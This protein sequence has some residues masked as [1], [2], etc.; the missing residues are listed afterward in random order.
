MN[1]EV[2]IKRHNYYLD[3]AEKIAK[4]GSCLRTNYGALIINKNDIVSTG[5]TKSPFGVNNCIDKKVCKR[6]ELDSPSGEY[7]ECF[8]V[9]AEM[10][11][12]IKANRNKLIG[13]TLYLVGV[14][15]NDNESIYSYKP[16]TDCCTI[17][18]R[19]IIDSGIKEVIIR[20]NKDDYKCNNK[21]LIIIIEG[22]LFSE[23]K[24]LGDKFYIF[25]QEIFKDYNKNINVSEYYFI[26]SNGD[27]EII[28]YSKNYLNYFFYP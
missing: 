18:K 16:N 15:Y 20:N 8:S 14:R 28:D 22:S 7:K 17:C 24:W 25:G 23:E 10:N 21:R 1:D 5:R 2:I 26:D 27:W 13:A 12:I 3:I 11:A 9:H 4:T 19:L 6:R